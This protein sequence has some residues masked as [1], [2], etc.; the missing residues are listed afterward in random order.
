[1]RGGLCR[2]ANLPFFGEPKA[3]EQG[4]ARHSITWQSPGVQGTLRHYES[5]DSVLTGE[6]GLRVVEAGA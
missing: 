4:A 6:H 5:C 2:K 1:M 3:G